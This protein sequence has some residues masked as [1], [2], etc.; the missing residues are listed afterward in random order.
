MRCEQHVLDMHL[1]CDECVY[2]LIGVFGGAEVGVAGDPKRRLPP[3][4]YP[5]K[6]QAATPP[7][8]NPDNP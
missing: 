2:V 3:P 1:R 5:T 6:I 4:R 7:K 8:P